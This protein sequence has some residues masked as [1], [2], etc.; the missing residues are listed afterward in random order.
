M[1]RNPWV[2][3]V[4]PVSWFGPGSTVII[5]LQHFSDSTGQNPTE[6]IESYSITTNMNT[7]RDR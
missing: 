4:C 6:S 1:S 3:C 7:A 2:S 5:T